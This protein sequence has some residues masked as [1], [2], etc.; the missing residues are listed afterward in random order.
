MGIC[1]RKTL[2]KHLLIHQLPS[3]ALILTDVLS[4]NPCSFSPCNKQAFLLKSSYWFWL[5]P[6][7]LTALQRMV[8]CQLLRE[9]WTRIVTVFCGDF[10]LLLQLELG[11]CSER[12]ALLAGWWLLADAETSYSRFGADPSDVFNSITPEDTHCKVGSCCGP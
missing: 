6:K 1:I 10:K 4:R 12:A 8:D 11:C 2:V 3:R 7:V 5:E 9:V